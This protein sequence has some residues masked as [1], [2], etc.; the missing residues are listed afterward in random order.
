MANT[1]HTHTRRGVVA[2]LATVTVAGCSG[3]ISRDAR[4]QIV[5]G[6]ERTLIR[7]TRDGTNRKVAEATPTSSSVVDAAPTD[8]EVRTVAYDTAVVDLAGAGGIE[9]D[10]ETVAR[11]ADG[12]DDPY[13]VV[14]L[15]LYNDDPHNEVPKGNSY[16]YRVTLNQLDRVMPGDRISATVDTDREVVAIEELLTID[17]A[18]E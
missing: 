11:I 5:G 6:V 14:V 10:D 8:L 18:G 3:L 17:A 9:T 1:A 4:Y 2:A 7:G 15:T 12:Y 13:G 16:G